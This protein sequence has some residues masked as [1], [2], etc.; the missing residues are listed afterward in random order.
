MFFDSLFEL[1]HKYVNGNVDSNVLDHAAAAAAAFADA[2]LKMAEVERIRADLGHSSD[3]VFHKA[4]VLDEE[5]VSDIVPDSEFES[6][7]DAVDDVDNS[8]SENVSVDSDDIVDEIDEIAGS[9]T[10]ESEFDVVDD[11]VDAD[12]SDYVES[13][14][15]SSSD[16]DDVDGFDRSPMTPDIP[17]ELSDVE[18]VVVERSSVS[19]SFGSGFDEEPDEDSVSEAVD[20]EASKDDTSVDGTIF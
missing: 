8:V 3:E 15:E 19:V 4:V 16:L 12:A 11:S 1:I 9:D 5:A 6:D 20:F 2:E 14:D 13:S 7:S 10:L 18:P 17:V